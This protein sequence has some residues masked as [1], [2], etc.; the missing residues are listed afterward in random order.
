MGLL[1]GIRISCQRWS[2][3]IC[4]RW[5]ISK[6]F[7]HD[8]SIYQVWKLGGQKEED[9]D[10]NGQRFILLR[11]PRGKVDLTPEN[12][13]EIVSEKN[14]Q[15]LSPAVNKWANADL[16]TTHC[17]GIWRAYPPVFQKKQKSPNTKLFLRKS[18]KKFLWLWAKFLPLFS[19]QVWQSKP[20][21]KLLR[22]NG[23]HSSSLRN[24]LQRR[25]ASQSSWRKYGHLF[26]CDKERSKV[27]KT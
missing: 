3:W 11:T 19:P 9:Y 27:G 21:K 10:R 8:V 16:T 7:A 17:W 22:K 14:G 18:D 20:V 12:I 26:D 24:K 13:S 4:W 5:T 25:I 2:C 6:A 15:A 1:G 23:Q